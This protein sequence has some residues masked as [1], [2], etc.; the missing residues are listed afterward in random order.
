MEQPDIWHVEALVFAFSDFAITCANIQ[1][2]CG[3][4]IQI[5]RLC[6]LSDELAGG[7]LMDVELCH[8]AP[9]PCTA[10]ISGG[11]IDCPK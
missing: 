9:P 10:P 8:P 5:G 6:Y 11:I 4:G 2:P 7:W 3:I 1:L